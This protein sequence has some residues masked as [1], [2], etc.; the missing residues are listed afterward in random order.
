MTRKVDRKRTGRA[1]QLHQKLPAILV[2]SIVVAGLIG[3]VWTALTPSSR[4]AAVGIIIPKLSATAIAGKTSFDANCAQC[5]GQNA[6][7]TE[8]GPPL[9]HKIYNPGHHGDAAFFLAAK[10]G[11]RQHHWPFGNMPAQPKLSEAEVATIVHYVRELQ[12]ANG[13]VYQPHKM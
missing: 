5:H 12:T 7:G 6:V 1:L 2:T 4:D 10:Q 9:V 13:L 8:K 3:V 11:V